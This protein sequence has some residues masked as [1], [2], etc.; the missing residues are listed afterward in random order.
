MVVAVVGIENSAVEGIEKVE[1]EKEGF[2]M[3]KEIA[4]K[5]VC[6]EKEQDILLYLIDRE[7]INYLSFLQ[8]DSDLSVRGLVDYYNYGYIGLVVEVVVDPDWNS[9]EVLKLVQL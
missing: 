1:I 9:S 6:I 2:G 3:D 7:N 4:K 5:M 8:V